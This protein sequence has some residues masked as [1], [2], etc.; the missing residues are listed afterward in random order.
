MKDELH[1]SDTLRNKL[2]QSISLTNPYQNDPKTQKSKHIKKLKT[3]SAS[4][5]FF[6]AWECVSLVLA[7]RTTVDF[8]VKDNF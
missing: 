6:Y 5:E 7:N 1:K 8:V 3:F 4:D 2:K